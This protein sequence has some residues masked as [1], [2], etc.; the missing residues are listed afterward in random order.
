[1]M[2]LGTALYAVGVSGMATAF[3]VVTDPV[4][5][6]AVSTALLAGLN[7]D[8]Q[9]YAV[10][11]AGSV[12][13]ALGT[14]AQAVGLLRART[15]PRWVPWMSLAIWASYLVP[16]NAGV[17]GLLVEVPVTVAALSIAWFLARSR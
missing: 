14:T 4:L 17:I 1:M 10:A 5:D 13:V 2:W 3:Y 8:P 12:L 16:T 15:V 6:D 7:S 9:T 11:I